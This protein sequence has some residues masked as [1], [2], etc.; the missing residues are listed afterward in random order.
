MLGVGCSFNVQEMLG[1]SR[2]K[3]NVRLFVQDVVLAGTMFIGTVITIV[4]IWCG[5]LFIV[6]GRKGDVG[7]QKKATQGMLYAIV[8]LVLVTCSYGIIQLVRY[9]AMT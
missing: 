2:G 3:T 5:I 7:M 6:A 1:F 4:L 8:G 9:I